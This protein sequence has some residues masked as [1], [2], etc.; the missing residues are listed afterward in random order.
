[1]SWVRDEGDDL[2]YVRCDACGYE[3]LPADFGGFGELPR[4]PAWWS[5]R[6]PAGIVPGGRAD[7]HYCWQCSQPPA[8][9]PA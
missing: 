2:R 4:P 5:T 1:M 8:R 6:T 3:E 7:R 9:V